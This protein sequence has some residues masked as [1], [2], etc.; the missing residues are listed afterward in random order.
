M[1][2]CMKNGQQVAQVKD[3]NGNMVDATQQNCTGE[4][5]SW[6]EGLK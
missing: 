5:G 2:T 1:G 6:E 4:A 3:G